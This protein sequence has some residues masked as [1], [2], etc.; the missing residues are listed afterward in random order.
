MKVKVVSKAQ[1]TSY[2]AMNM[3]SD[4]YFIIFDLAKAQNDT[5]W[6]GYLTCSKV[7][8]DKFESVMSISICTLGE[9]KLAFNTLDDFMYMRLLIKEWLACFDLH[10]KMEK[11]SMKQWE[12]VQLAIQNVRPN[13]YTGGLSHHEEERYFYF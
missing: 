10:T 6:I 2:P 5:R 4:L 12:A 11:V 9:S 8:T 1:T 3:M 7:L 13:F